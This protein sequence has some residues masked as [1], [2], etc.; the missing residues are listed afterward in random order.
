MG[1]G[2]RVEAPGAGEWVASFGGDACDLRG[3]MKWRERFAPE[4]E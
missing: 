2:I 1:A 4:A 3:G